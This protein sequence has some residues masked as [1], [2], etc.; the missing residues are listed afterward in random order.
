M[1]ADIAAW[2]KTLQPGD[3]VAVRESWSGADYKIEPV[4]RFTKTQVV[5]RNKVNERCPSRF[6][7]HDGYE[8][9]DSFGGCRIVPITPEI[10]AAIQLKRLRA[11]LR[12]DLNKL[13]IF[14]LDASQCIRVQAV[15]DVIEQE[16][17]APAANEAPPPV[18]G[19]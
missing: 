13:A 2:I 6:R 10:E 14:S 17:A 19:D 15:L 12:A 7:L 3:K 8:V 11:R 5:V 1:S 18:H 16:R 4:L 9:G